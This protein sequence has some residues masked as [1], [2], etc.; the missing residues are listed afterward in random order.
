MEKLELCYESYPPSGL[1][2]ELRRLVDLAYEA[3]EKAYAP[4]SG[5]NVAALAELSDGDVISA[6]NQESVSFPVG[7][8]AERALLFSHFNNNDTQR[9]IKRVVI[10]AKNGGVV[11]EV[12]PCGMCRQ[13]LLDAQIRQGSNISIIFASGGRFLVLPTADLLLPFSFKEF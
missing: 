9:T 3:T 13:S 6:T 11:Q 10:V 1:P 4:Y 8:C 5:F 2:Q 12:S 7:I